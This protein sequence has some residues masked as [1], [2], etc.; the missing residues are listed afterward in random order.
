M[1][2]RLKETMNGLDRKLWRGK[3]LKQTTTDKA[4][5]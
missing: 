2:E 1:V 3:R 5:S 4:R